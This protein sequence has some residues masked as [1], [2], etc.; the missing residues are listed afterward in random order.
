VKAVHAGTDHEDAAQLSRLA[1]YLD[2]HGVTASTETLTI[3]H[4][5][6]ARTLIEAASAADIDFLV[7]G[8]FGAPGWQYALGRDDTTALLKGTDFAILMVH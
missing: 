7:M 1:N 6:I 5:S 4:R 2:R 3:D 8:G